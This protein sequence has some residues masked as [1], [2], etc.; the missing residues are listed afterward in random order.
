MAPTPQMTLRVDRDRAARWKSASERSA[1]TVSEQ[2]RDLMDAWS[3]L[4]LESDGS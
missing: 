4:V 2:I 1:T 3:S